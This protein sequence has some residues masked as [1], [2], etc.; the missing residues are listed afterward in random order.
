[1][2]IYVYLVFVVIVHSALGE[3]L[4][5]KQKQ[6]DCNAVPYQISNYSAQWYPIYFSKSLNKNPLP[7]YLFSF[8]SIET[9]PC[10]KV[11]TNERFKVVDADTK[12]RA[13]ICG[14]ELERCEI[15]PEVNPPM[16]NYP[17]QG[18]MK[19]RIMQENE[20]FVAILFCDTFIHDHKN[21]TSIGIIVGSRQDPTE[22]FT[23]NFP[24][25]EFA[26]NLE[27][28]MVP[29]NTFVRSIG[30]QWSHFIHNITNTECKHKCSSYFCKVQQEKNKNIKYLFIIPFIIL[31][32][33]FIGLIIRFLHKNKNSVEIIPNY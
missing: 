20:N 11:S 22:L 14:M 29:I 17:L 32:I 27:K 19:T 26:E 13:T 31:I 25:E 4:F 33:I 1:M 8:A 5:V 15:S 16:F 3:I 30:Y 10:W 9:A 24:T 7:R 28:F 12:E 21:E 18:I 23:K 2:S 6:I